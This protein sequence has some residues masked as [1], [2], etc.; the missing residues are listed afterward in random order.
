MEKQNLPRELRSRVEQY[1]SYLW[2]AHGTFELSNTSLKFL[3][4]APTTEIYT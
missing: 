3:S 1:Y 2:H 4:A